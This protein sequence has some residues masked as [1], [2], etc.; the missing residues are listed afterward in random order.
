M[1]S[2]QST[3]D[4]S[5]FEEDM[6]SEE[7]YQDNN[8]NS[9]LTDEIE[10]QIIPPKKDYEVLSKESLMEKA[11]K[12][13]EEVNSICNLTTSVTSA[14][15][16]KYEWSKEKA[17]EKYMENPTKV[18]KEVGCL[19]ENDFPLN[20]LETQP[21]ECNICMDEVEQMERM[22]CGDEFCKRCW[23]EY[24]ENQIESGPKC[25]FAECMKTGCRLICREEF[26]KKIVSES[27]VNRYLFFLERSFV[28]HNPRVKWCP[29]PG[30]SFAISCEIKNR[31]DPVTCSCGFCFCFIC[32]D[33]DIGDHS[34]CDCKK[35]KKWMKKN[36]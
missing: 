36:L 8:D 25:V 30:C 4:L 22:E 6:N 2:E 9:S 19:P 20:D 24:L 17:I 1:D 13:I 32:S 28:D 14:L 16:R 15:L 34:P 5:N 18:L 33:S 26:Y 7:D 23:K 29:S 21:R 27:H 10:K 11:G 31:E 12:L 35:A 3:E